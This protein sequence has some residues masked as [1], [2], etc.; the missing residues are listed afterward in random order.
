MLTRLSG[1]GKTSGLELGQM[2][3]KGADLLHI[4]D[5][6]VS[7]FVLYFDRD[8]ALAELG[9]AREADG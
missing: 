5:G 7:R 6:R 8:H 1:R 3:A 9:L 2:Q 4:R